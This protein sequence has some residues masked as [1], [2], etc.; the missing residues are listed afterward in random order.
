MRTVQ[1]EELTLDA[2][3]P[4]GSFASMVNP[5]AERFE[6]ESRAFFR[7][8]IQQNLGGDTAASFSTCRVELRDMVITHIEHHSRTSEGI[9]PLDNDILIH[10]L[11]ATR[12]GEDVSM[13]KL[14]VF[15]V[16]Q[17]TLVILRPGVWHHAPYTPNEQPVNVL[18]MLPERAYANDCTLICLP[19]S[20]HVRIVSE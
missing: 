16:P 20:D 18:I 15:R 6:G 10:V 9:L 11:A 17:Y 14:R 5:E 12:P 2:F 3:L 13:E 4:F 1:V 7:D 8:M 19:D